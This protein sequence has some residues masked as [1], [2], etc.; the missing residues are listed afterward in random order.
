MFFFDL[1]FLHMLGFIQIIIQYNVDV[2]S[3]LKCHLF[4]VQL[5]RI[6][7]AFDHILHLLCFLFFTIVT[8]IARGD[9]SLYTCH[10][11]WMIRT[12]AHHF[13]GIV[14][15]NAMIVLYNFLFRKF[16]IIMKDTSHSVIR[17]LLCKI[18]S[19]HLIRSIENIWM[20]RKMPGSD[21]EN[22]IWCLDY[23]IS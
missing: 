22:S 15:I 2:Y 17:K 14:I 12:P 10:I 3:T 9:I 13:D 1:Y 23:C 6:I 21:N 8:G 16:D 7:V 18:H 5:C 20:S 19:R 4:I 11:V